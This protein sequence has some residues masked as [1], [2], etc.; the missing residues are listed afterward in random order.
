MIMKLKNIIMEMKKKII[1]KLSKILSIVILYGTDS[2]YSYGYCQGEIKL[3]FAWF[4]IVFTFTSSSYLLFCRYCLHSLCQFSDSIF[5]LNFLLQFF[6]S[7]FL[8][9]FITFLLLYSLDF[10]Q[11]NIELRKWYGKSYKFLCNPL[12]L[13]FSISDTNV[14]NLLSIQKLKKNLSLSPTEFFKNL[15]MSKEDFIL[16]FRTN[17]SNLYADI[18]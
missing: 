11:E 17:I 15:K 7:F 14:I 6:I 9:I 3:F 12:S 13:P 5:H 16:E 8:I 10:L 18:R 2:T 4:W 1:Q